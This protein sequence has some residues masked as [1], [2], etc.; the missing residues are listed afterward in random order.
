MA[1]RI[2]PGDSGWPD[3]VERAH[4]NGYITEEELC[5]RLALHRFI[6]PSLDLE[7][8]LGGEPAEMPAAAQEPPLGPAPEPLLE[9]EP[10]LEPR[11]R[12]AGRQSAPASAPSDSASTDLA[13]VPPQN[14]DA[15]ESLLGALLTAGVDGASG[16]A[17]I[18]EVVAMLEPE[19]F[20]R[21]ERGGL[22]FASIARL[23]VAGHPIDPIS[24]A[25][26]IEAC[27][28]LERVGGRGRIHELA[29]IAPTWTNARH[30]AGL[31]LEAA[32]RRSEEEVAKTW[33]AATAAGGLTAHPRLRERITAMLES[34]PAEVY[35]ELS[36]AVD[37]ATWLES[38]PADTP[39][40]W[41]NGR[42]VLWPEGEPLMIYGPDGVGKTTLAEQ[43]ILH[44]IG[45]RRDLLLEMPVTTSEGRVLYIAAD[46]PKQA[47]RSLARMVGEN[48]YE[49]L[50]ERL[51]VWEGPL[52]FDLSESPRRL[53]DFTRRLGADTVVI[54]SV[55]DVAL[56]LV[57]DEVGSRVNLAFQLLIANGIELVVDHH[58]RKDPAGTPAKPKT[59]ED[60]YG[61]RWIVAG[62]GS[63][64][65][66]WGKAGDLVLELSHLKQPAEELSP[67]KVLHDH[68]RG[69]TSLYEQE[70]LEQALW[71]AAAGLTV[72][73]GARHLYGGDKPD[74]NQRE[75]ARRQLDKLIEKGVSERRDD[76]DGTARY[77][78]H[79]GGR[80]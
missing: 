50:R 54:D 48:E 13:P 30:H 67:A 52:P 40:I 32:R 39:A 16:H 77:F 76:D 26:E 66:L 43:L 33:L 20:Y 1:Q 10:S 7:P 3:L 28:E 31:V 44:R 63:V 51:T 74:P 62:M 45:V 34:D 35:D 69:V 17:R 6:E 57:K 71:R 49:L 61:S 68:E 14:L 41:G 65:L 59:L 15:E 21:R 18:A 23:H 79:E 37:G 55:K 2:P 53:L 25:A 58:P 27:G 46:R 73:D 56:D 29:A 64:L 9:P 19:H 5:E 70:G 78:P 38:A 72:T 11:E 60:V 75:K 80:A 36:R 22:V 12:V 8:D 47:R 24:V 42:V 4:A